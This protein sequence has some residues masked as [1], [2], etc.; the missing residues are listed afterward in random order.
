M[1]YWVSRS[2]QGLEMNSEF[3]L[4]ILNL[5]NWLKK[6]IIDAFSSCLLTGCSLQEPKSEFLVAF[7]PFSACVFQCAPDSTDSVASILV[8]A[9]NL[10]TAHVYLG[11]GSD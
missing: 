5:R 10:P 11:A 9:G 4:W 6:E 2:I 3:M 7:F 1:L 8:T